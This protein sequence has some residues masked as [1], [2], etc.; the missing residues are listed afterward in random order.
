[1]RFK[2]FE[3]KNSSRS[4]RGGF[5]HDSALYFDGVQI[6]K[7]SVH[8]YNRT[9]ED[10]Q[11]QTSM[12]KVVEDMI[13]WNTNQIKRQVCSAHDWKR[14]NDTRRKTIHG[15]F[16]TADFG[17][18]TGKD[19]LDL[20]DKINNKEQ[21]PD[22]VLNSMKAFLMLG[23]LMSEKQDTADAVKYKEKIVFAT[24]RNK[25]PNWQKPNDWDCL[26]DAE[27]LERLNKIQTI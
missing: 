11:F 20:L 25:I 21:E 2:K 14:L 7:T 8:Y 26:N 19:L 16:K 17:G 23:D 3:I 15:H 10:Y 22:P 5:S 12:R 27:K 9:W 13:N 4:R 1:M 6:N 24:M 18:Y